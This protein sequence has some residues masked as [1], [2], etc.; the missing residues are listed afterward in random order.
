M[1]GLG[2]GLIS[3]RPGSE[4]TEGTDEI[5]GLDYALGSQR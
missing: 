2:L 3:S 4:S 5:A 1:A